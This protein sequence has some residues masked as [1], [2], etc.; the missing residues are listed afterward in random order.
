MLTLSSN[1]EL[2]P[3]FFGFD[4]IVM[5]DQLKHMTLVLADHNLI[6]GDYSNVK[7]GND[8][9]FHDKVTFLFL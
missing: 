8:W 3:I 1:G 6:K 9:P 2:V 4:Q 5:T 7:N